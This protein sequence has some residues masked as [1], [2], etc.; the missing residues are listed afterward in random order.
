[1]I[2][3]DSLEPW[4]RETLT[5]VPAVPR[6]VMHALQLAE[7]DVERWCSS[8][9]DEDL[10]ARPAGL[11]SVA[12]HVQ[13]I[14][15]SLD[16]LLTYAEGCSLSASQF[17]ALKTEQEGAGKA[18]LFAEFVSSLEAARERVRKLRLSELAERRFVGQKQLPAT[19]GGLL[20][21][22]ADHTQRHVG[23]AITTAKVLINT[24]HHM[25][26]QCAE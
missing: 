13:H 19:L 7:E 12:F 24:R 25:Q 17:E 10:N 5:E 21:H 26:M 11:A 9:S 8:L 20:V 15:R 16:R 18:E 3:G 22:I 14:A 1:M 6:A 23:Q 4:L 2:E